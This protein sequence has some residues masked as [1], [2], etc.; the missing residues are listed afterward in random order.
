VTTLGH[1]AFELTVYKVVG[2]Y[3]AARAREFGSANYD[4]VRTD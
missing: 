3:V 2:K 4:V 1:D